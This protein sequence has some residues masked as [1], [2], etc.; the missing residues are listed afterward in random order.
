MANSPADSLLV[1]G[2]HAMLCASS[3]E[4][5]VRHGCAAEAWSEAAT[6]AMATPAYVVGPA[7]G[8]GLEGPLH[9]CRAHAYTRAVDA[10]PLA[11][12]LECKLGGSPRYSAPSPPPP[13]SSILLSVCRT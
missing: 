4:D 12:G 1:A 5:G 13:R 2:A 7:S 9:P 6:V 11:S 3:A 8:I 10:G